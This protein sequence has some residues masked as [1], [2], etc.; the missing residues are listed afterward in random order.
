MCCSDL[1][2][3]KRSECSL[4]NYNGREFVSLKEK[5][6]KAL[7]DDFAL[8]LA[9]FRRSLTTTISAGR[10]LLLQL[11]LVDVISIF[12][13]ARP[14]PNS[15]RGHVTKHL[16]GQEGQ[17]TPAVYDDCFRLTN[18]LSASRNKIHQYLFSLRCYTLTAILSHLLPGLAYPG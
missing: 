7:K 17:H 4:E 11:W 2:T 18:T 10:A 5:Q 1:M 13:S 15:F 6:R 16:A 9:A 14:F 3:R 12:L 8:L